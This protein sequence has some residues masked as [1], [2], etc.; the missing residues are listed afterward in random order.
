[1]AEQKLEIYIWYCICNV[2]LSLYSTRKS[3]TC[4]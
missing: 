2:E 4:T 3:R 1:V